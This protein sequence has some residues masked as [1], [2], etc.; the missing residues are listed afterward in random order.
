MEIDVALSSDRIVEIGQAFFKSKALLSAV[1]LNLFTVLAAEGPLDTAD[2]CERVGLSDRSARDFLDALVA[3]RLLNRSDDQRYANTSET[4]LFLDRRKATYSGGFLELCNARLYRS[5]ADLTSVLQTGRP[6]S[7]D[8]GDGHL[9][10]QYGRMYSNPVDQ[11]IFLKGMTSG[12]LPVA[13]A[14]AAKFSWRDCGTV[15]DVGCAEGCLLVEVAKAHVHIHG[16]GFDLPTVQAP[17]ESYVQVNGVADRLAFRPGDFHA[18]TLPAADVIVM[19]R[20]LHNWNL[21][22]KKRL[23]TKAWAA[24]PVGGT[25]LVY[26]RLIDDDRRA[27]ATALLASLN[28][29]VVTSGGFD[30]TGADCVEWMRETGFRRIRVE[31]LVASHSMVIATK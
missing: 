20:V 15:V 6:E 23:L 11:Q 4:D 17:F 1:E 14:I 5:W 3:L 2:I 18:D 24:L 25:L 7:H 9:D 22:T 27:N 29:L 8:D 21:D 19:G 16:Y 13:K 26:E 28:M 31:P 30:F 12:T 10:D